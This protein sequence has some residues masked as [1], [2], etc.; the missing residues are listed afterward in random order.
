MKTFTTIM[1][2]LLIINNCSAQNNEKALIRVKYNFTHQTDSNDKKSIY[3]EN[4]LLVSGKNV[5]AYLSYDGVIKDLEAKKS[6]EQ[7]VKEQ[8]GNITAIRMPTSSRSVN[9]ITMFHFLKDEKLIT[10]ERI[11]VVYQTEQAIDKLNWIIKTDTKKIEG[12]NCKLATTKFKGRN[13]LAWFA[14]EIPINAGPWKLNGLPGLII[15]AEDDQEQIKF[16]F[17]G[18][19][20]VDQ[21][22]ARKEFDPNDKLSVPFFG[23]GEILTATE[24]I[25]PTRNVQHT[26][27]D[28][29]KSLKKA[30]AADPQG[31]ARAQLAGMGMNLTPSSQGNPQ[32]APKKLIFNNPIEKEISDKLK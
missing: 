27:V 25:I 26:T 28:E 12:I 4:M 14:E 29:L 7:Q 15:Q 16:H 24:I 19:E 5:S 18:L 20:Q 8:N 21:L 3:Q 11:G 9:P 2:A 30:R 32:P 31:F 13:W 1:M 23:N 6:F 17:A 22:A 10:Q